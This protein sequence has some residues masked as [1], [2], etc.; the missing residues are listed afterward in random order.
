M[1]S[2]FL[3][4]VVFSRSA[5]RT[6]IPSGASASTE[7]SKRFLFSFARPT[8]LMAFKVLMVNITHSPSGT[9]P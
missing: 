9:A 7:T 8:G 4:K 5:L 6:R 3:L 2:R 1:A